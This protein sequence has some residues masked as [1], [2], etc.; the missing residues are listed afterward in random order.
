MSPTNA[1]KGSMLILIEASIIHS[2]PTAN[3][4]E[5]EFGI[6]Q[7]AIVAKIAPIAK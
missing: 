1:R 3:Q 6:M 2:I 5:G 7:R 4:S